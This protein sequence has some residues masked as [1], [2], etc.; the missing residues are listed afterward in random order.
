[1]NDIPRWQLISDDS[2]WM[3]PAEI[4]LSTV[5]MREDWYDLFGYQFESCLF[6]AKGNSDVVCRYETKEE[7]IKGHIELEKKYGLKRCIKSKI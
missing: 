6:F 7:A 3:F 4:S 2:V 1:M 5:Q